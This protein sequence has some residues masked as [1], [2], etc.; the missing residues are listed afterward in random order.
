MM[1]S[2]QLVSQFQ[3]M[4]LEQNEDENDMDKTVEK[5]ASS[6]QLPQT[7]NLPADRAGGDKGEVEPE[8]MA[9]G[10]QDR[11]VGRQW[12]LQDAARE[13]ASSEAMA[14]HSEASVKMSS[15]QRQLD[16]WTRNLQLANSQVRLSNPRLILRKREEQAK[17]VE[18]IEQQQQEQEKNEESKDT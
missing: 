2:A 15:G 7:F 10:S 3:P 17:S 16:L 13:R 14:S 5:S 12:S 1:Q 11:R 8:Q 18:V 4:G 6:V 9:V